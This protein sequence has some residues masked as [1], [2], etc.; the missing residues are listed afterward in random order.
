MLGDVLVVLAMLLE[1]VL[2]G[3]HHGSGPLLG[4][5]LGP[6]LVIVLA[7]VLAAVLREVLVLLLEELL[8]DKLVLLGLVELL[9]VV[10]VELIVVVVVLVLTLEADEVL[11][12]VLGPVVG[13]MLTV[14]VGPLLLDV[15][16]VVLLV[17]VGGAA[18]GTYPSVE[19]PACMQSAMSKPHCRVLGHV[20]KAPPTVIADGH[21][22]RPDPRTYTYGLLQLTWQDS[23]GCKP[24]QPD[25]S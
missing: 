15:L 6:L 13:P 8:V 23:P 25:T 4:P 20:N 7:V 19:M 9:V 2:V 21:V 22:T 3:L 24:S 11:V 12:I 14:L 10:V 18:P 16:L 1:A 5:K 17:G